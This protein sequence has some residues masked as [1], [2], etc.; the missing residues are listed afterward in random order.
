MYR[1]TQNSKEACCSSVSVDPPSIRNRV[2]FLYLTAALAYL[3]TSPPNSPHTLSIITIRAPKIAV[4][5]MEQNVFPVI[6]VRLHL[7]CLEAQFLFI[8]ISTRQSEM[9][10]VHAL[11]FVPAA[12]FP[13]QVHPRRS[14]SGLSN[15]GLPIIIGSSR[16]AC[17]DRVHSLHDAGNQRLLSPHRE[18]NERGALHTYSYTA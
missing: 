2:I 9:R 11:Q 16:D 8:S 14:N 10:D 7:H 13:A 17:T 5:P 4:A 12:L 3:P 15:C 1:L 18:T 6:R